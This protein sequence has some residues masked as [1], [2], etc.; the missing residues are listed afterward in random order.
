MG[1][2]PTTFCMAN[3]SERSH[4]FAPV[5]S[6]RLLPG[7]PVGRANATARERTSNL[8]ILATAQDR[9][10]TGDPVRECQAQ[11]TVAHNGD[12]CY[13]WGRTDHRN[14]SI[15]RSVSPARASRQFSSSSS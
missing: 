10:L 11:H 8:A 2:E 3:E 4:P 9:H 12:C 5:R 13:V 15:S 14:G 7:F 1:L 6:N